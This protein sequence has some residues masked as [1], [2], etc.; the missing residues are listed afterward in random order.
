MEQGAGG[1][2]DVMT[3]IGGK[4]Q[5]AVVQLVTGTWLRKIGDEKAF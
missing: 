3:F 2:W 1:K 4:E 5:R